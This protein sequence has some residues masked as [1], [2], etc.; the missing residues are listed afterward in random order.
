[1]CYVIQ[2]ISNQ[3]LSPVAKKKQNNTVHL[4]Q[5]NSWKSVHVLSLNC[6]SI[7]NSFYLLLNQNNNFSNAKKVFQILQHSSQSKSYNNAFAVSRYPSLYICLYPLGEKQH[8]MY[9]QFTYN[10]KGYHTK[11]WNIYKCFCCVVDR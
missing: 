6:L 9:R 2:N 10:G 11:P 7:S 4:Q 8:W 1:M 3:T 5:S